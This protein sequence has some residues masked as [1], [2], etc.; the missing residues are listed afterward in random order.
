MEMMARR[1]P[2]I[3]EE[4]DYYTIGEVASLL[5]IPSHTLRFWEEEFEELK[6]NKNY[7]GHRLYTNYDI[8]IAKI[9][10]KLM[11]EELYTLEGAKKKLKR[12]LKERESM[13]GESGSLNK[14]REIKE[15]LLKILT[16]L[17]ENSIK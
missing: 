10:K 13:Q 17:N 2:K 11:H 3:I 9:I 4:K 16:M 12:I 14:L 7:K 1:I 8:E 5:N 15:K 6:P